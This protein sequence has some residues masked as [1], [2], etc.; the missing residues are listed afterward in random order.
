MSDA[1]RATDTLW[2]KISGLDLSAG[3]KT[4]A[5]AKEIIQSALDAFAAEQT[6]RAEAWERK[7]AERARELAAAEA[8]VERLRTGLMNAR[9]SYHHEMHRVRMVSVERCSS[10]VCAEATALL[11]PTVPPSGEPR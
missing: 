4:A 10:P 3:P 1:A 8:Q 11:A 2:R 5:F 9:E 6:A 7:S